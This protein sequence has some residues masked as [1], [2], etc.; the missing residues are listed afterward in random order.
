MEARQ[1]PPKTLDGKRKRP[2]RIRYVTILI[3]LGENVTILIIFD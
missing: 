3:F 2:H 1:K